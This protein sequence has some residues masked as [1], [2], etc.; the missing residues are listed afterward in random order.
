M[1]NLY[2]LVGVENPTDYKVTWTDIKPKVTGRQGHENVLRT[3]GPQLL[4]DAQHVE[5]PLECWEL[6]FHKGDGRNSGSLDKQKNRTSTLSNGRG[7]T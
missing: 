5:S 2:L 7:S 4:G 1:C 6:F 3:P